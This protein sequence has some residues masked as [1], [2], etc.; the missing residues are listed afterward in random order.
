MRRT[1]LTRRRV[2]ALL[3]AVALVLASEAKVDRELEKPHVR[4]AMTIDLVTLIDNAWEHIAA[5]FLP[6][7]QEDRR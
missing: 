2:R 4:K 7:A 3:E 5:Q 6:T 1:S